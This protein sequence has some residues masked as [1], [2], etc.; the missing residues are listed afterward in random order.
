MA[1]RG[2][3]QEDAF[4]EIHEINVTPFIDVILV[5][6]I[7]FMVAAPLSTV[8]VN[9]DLPASTANPAPRGQA[10]VLDGETGPYLTLGEAPIARGNLAS[11]LD[12]ETQGDKEQRVFVRAG[13]AVPYGEVMELMNLLR[14][15][16]Y[17]KIGLVGMEAASGGPAR[18]ESARKV[19]GDV[20][21]RYQAAGDKTMTMATI[22]PADKE[23][24]TPMDVRRRGGRPCPWRDCFLAHVYTRFSSSRRSTSS[25]DND[26]ARACGCRASNGD[27]RRNHAGTA[28]D[29][30]RSRGGRTAAN[31]DG[32]GI[33]PAP[34]PAV[35]LMTPPKPKLKPKK[36]VKEMPKPVVKL[37][38][39]PPAPRTSAPPRAAAASTTAS[40]RAASAAEAAAYRSAWSAA[41]SWS[42]HYPEAARARGEQGTVRLAITIGRSGHVISAHVVASSGSSILDQAALEMARNASGRP[43]PPEMG[44]SVSVTVPVRYSMR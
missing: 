2:S 38:R 13:R 34:K 3:Q 8:D 41:M 39:E 15:A 21:I 10:A 24:A 31:I 36:I 4:E 33:A 11:V 42:R 20:A 43:L 22:L 27:A 32:S 14:G 5:L 7:I 12:A 16:G 19:H 28:N 23:R 40:S 9:V 30:G 29:T 44:S 1:I 18:D 35:V 37:T 25:D 6:L 26:R 17:L